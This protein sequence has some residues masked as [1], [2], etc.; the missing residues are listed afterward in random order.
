MFF[1]VFSFYA[2]SSGNS[3]IQHHLLCNRILFY[4]LPHVYF[5]ILIPLRNWSSLS[6]LGSSCTCCVGSIQVSETI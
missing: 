5:P 3:P 2:S 4:F 1:T 6:L